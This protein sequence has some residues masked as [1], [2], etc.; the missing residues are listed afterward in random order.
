MRLRSKLLLFVAIPTGAAVALG[1]ASVASSWQS[2]AADQRSETL[3]S[4]SIKVSH[5]AFEIETERD[6]IVW[7]IAAGPDGREGQLTA[8]P[9]ASVKQASDGQLEVVRQQERFA[10]LWVKTVQASAADLGSAYSRGV[11][12]GAQAVVAVLRDLPGLRRQSLDTHLPATQ[13]VEDFDKVVGVLLAL[14]DQ[15]ALSSADPQFASTARAMVAIARQED[16]YSVQRAIVMYGLVAQHLNPDMLDELDASIANQ[17]A[18]LTQFQNFGATSQV[19]MFNASQATTL[20]DRAVADEQEVIK[21]TSQIARLPIV[22][23]DWY[24]SVSDVIAA[25]QKF[26]ETLAASAVDRAKAMRE[27]AIIS[28]DV[29]GG[30][31]LLV[32][33]FSLVLGVFIWRSDGEPGRSMLAKRRRQVPLTP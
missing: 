18:D 10:D 27:R 12:A 5:L 32:L 19:E 11:Q 8:H 13:V 4:L 28:A 1:G 3:A 25:N 33:L 22:P 16:E 26:E 9:V 2:A 24:G 23:T 31:I 30:V 6:T 29:I 21:N 17:K 14:D 7:Y 20:E 15:V